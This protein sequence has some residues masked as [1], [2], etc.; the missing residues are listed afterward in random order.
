M[1]DAWSSGDYD[2]DRPHDVLNE[3]DDSPEKDY[4]A[5]LTLVMQVWWDEDS[6]GT[7]SHHDDHHLRDE[8]VIGTVAENDVC[9]SKWCVE[10]WIH[11]S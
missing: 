1:C 4:V 5:N 2:Y 11:Q 9:H 3:D 7:S 8:H 6:L 10:Q